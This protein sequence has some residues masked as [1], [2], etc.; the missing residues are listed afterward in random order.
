[1]IWVRE[2]GGGANCQLGYVKPA[3]MCPCSGPCGCGR[4]ARAHRM[5]DT[6]VIAPIEE[7]RRS[8]RRRSGLYIE[9]GGLRKLSINRLVEKP[10]GKPP[11][12]ESN[13]LAL[14][15]HLALIICKGP[16]YH[17]ILS[18]KKLRFALNVGSSVAA[19]YD[20]S[21]EKPAFGYEMRV[22]STFCSHMPAQLF[23]LGTTR[24]TSPL[25]V[26]RPHSHISWRLEWFLGHGNRTDGII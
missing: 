12:I 19:V 9:A 16:R 7:T 18:D 1:M 25:G 21:L 17:D 13:D 5:P 14:A 6:T 20:S 3:L 22:F 8:S 15:F 10:D 23:V 24:A 26:S 4:G 2:R 11:G